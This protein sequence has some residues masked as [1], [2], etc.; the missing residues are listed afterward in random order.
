MGLTW[1]WSRMASLSLGMVCRR[2]GAFYNW[3]KV[4]IGL[5]LCVF[6]KKIL[7]K[8]CAKSLQITWMHFF[9]VRMGLASHL[10]RGLWQAVIHLLVAK[11]LNWSTWDWHGFI[12]LAVDVEWKLT[13]LDLVKMRDLSR[14][15]LGQ[16][17]LGVS[18]NNCNF[19]VIAKISFAI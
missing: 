5:F 7:L 12:E 1:G 17:F 2:S 13:F 11:L 18:S 19:V 6:L 9:F 3:R 8:F 14:L 4:K 15:N 16:D 10:L